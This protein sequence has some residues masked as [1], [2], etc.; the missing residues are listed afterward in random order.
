M[1][2]TIYRHGDH[3]VVRISFPGGKKSKPVHLPPDIEEEQARTT[4]DAMHRRAR[5]KLAAAKAKAPEQ[6]CDAYAERVFAHREAIGYTGTRQDLSRWKTWASPVIG[7]L[8]A[9]AVDA[10]AVEPI[11][12][13][14]DR[15]VRA[16][17][18]LPKTASLAWGVVT[19]IFA[20]SCESKEPSLRIRPRGDNPCKG[21]RGPDTDAG[22]VCGWLYP[23]EALQ[24]FACDR[25]PL[26][27]RRLIALAIYLYLRPGEI[28]ALEVT[29]VDR[30]AG[31]VSIHRAADRS[32]GRGATKKTK[33]HLVR[34]VPLEP[35]VMPLI[36]TLIAE[37]R[38]AGRKTLISMPPVGDLAEGLRTYLTRAGITREEL[39]A[40]DESRRPIRFYDLR[41]TGITWRALRGD[42]PLALQRAAGHESLETT[43]GYIRAAA[44][45]GLG[46]GAPFPALPPQLL[47]S[48]P[49]TTQVPVIEMPIETSAIEGSVPS[50]IRTRVETQDSSTS[51]PNPRIG[52]PFGGM[53]G[54]AAR[55]LS[56]VLSGPL[57][58]V[59]TLAEDAAR[60]T[61]AAIAAGDPGEARA[62]CLEL[63]NLC[64]FGGARRRGIPRYVTD[65]RT[66]R[67]QTVSAWAR[68]LG[69]TS[70]GLTARL[71][72]M[73]V[74]RAL[75][76]AKRA[77]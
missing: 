7:S 29:A 31:F 68:E 53:E 39:F 72:T 54:G 20:E 75:V 34:R 4:A 77:A 12:T 56:E 71:D 26:R 59:V 32:K 1:A 40:D 14:L 6:S 58:G 21:I 70:Q 73:P 23:R 35:A 33:T 15:A 60:R 11:V 37:A 66:G 30:I 19:S 74:E 62:A 61:V 57:S 18:I 52:T 64:R 55:A 67:T 22:R 51:A 76:P 41:A 65:P 28:E 49:D 17:E 2:G 63:L 43:Q 38:H 13:R 48:K 8:S 5:E 9:V 10:D 50:G 24:L 25:V 47:D 69:R 46:V 36:D 45:V 3:W 44:D 42:L 27:W 16:K